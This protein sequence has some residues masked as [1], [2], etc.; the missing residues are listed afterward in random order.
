MRNKVQANILCCWEGKICRALRQSLGLLAQCGGL[1]LTEGACHQQQ[2]KSMHKGLVDALPSS[3]T[4]QGAC[5][6]C[7]P[8]M[9]RVSSGKS[10][11]GMGSPRQDS[12]PRPP[13]SPT[14][15]SW[16]GGMRLKRGQVQACMLYAPSL[17]MHVTGTALQQRT[18][19]LKPPCSMGCAAHLEQRLCHRQARGAHNSVSI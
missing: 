10:P 2:L 8:P 1:L 11:A 19:L 7:L 12:C 4:S 3:C 13:T 15:V 16:A 14:A 17:C 5:P 6:G 18:L 9:A